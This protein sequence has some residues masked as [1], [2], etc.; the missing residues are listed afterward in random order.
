M[1]SSDSFLKKIAEL[2]PWLDRSAKDELAA[3][4]ELQNLFP[5]LTLKQLVAELKKYQKARRLSPEGFGER[6]RDWLESSPRDSDERATLVRDFTLLKAE[7]VKKIAKEFDL[8]VAS[9]KKD[10]AAFETWLTTGIKPPSAEELLREELSEQARRILEI[11]DEV[12]EQLTQAAIESIMTI[13]EQIKK[14]YKT[15]G[16]REFL[17]LVGYPPVKPSD[18]GPVLTKMVR[19]KLESLSVDRFKAREIDSQG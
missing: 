12:P 15:V 11:R 7:N 19:H 3:I 18:S 5:G 2:A 8:N 13:V 16:F 17:R 9:G 4:V 10:V 14:K 6:L 1:S